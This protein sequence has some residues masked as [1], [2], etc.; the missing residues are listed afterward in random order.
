MDLPIISMAKKEEEIF[1]PGSHQSIKL[2]SHSE[3]F[4]LLQR[5]RD[6]AHRFAISYHRKIRSESMRYSKLD[7][8]PSVGVDRK[9]ELLKKFRSIEEIKNATIEEISRVPGI[10]IKIAKNIKQFWR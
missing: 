1:K 9:R 7:F 5:V 4:Y 10:G 2:P 6:E 3:A 8:I